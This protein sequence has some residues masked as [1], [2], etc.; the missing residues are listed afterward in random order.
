MDV[1]SQ[2]AHVL[3]L[4]TIFSSAMHA[5]MTSQLNCAFVALYVGNLQG[6]M[7]LRCIRIMLLKHCMLATY[8]VGCPQ[9]ASE[10]CFSS[11]VCWQPTG[12][13][14]LKMHQNCALGIQLFFLVSFVPQSLFLPRVPLVHLRLDAFLS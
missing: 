9:D 2:L 8:R 4:L 6:G 12:W 7:P 11:T 1:S 10:L 3:R 14:V 5:F 13:D